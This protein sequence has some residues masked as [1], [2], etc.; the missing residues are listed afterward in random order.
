M[1]N[2][3]HEKLFTQNVTNVTFSF[4]TSPNTNPTR[5]S[6]GTGTWH[7]MPPPV[8]KSGGDTSPVS[9]TKLRPC[10]CTYSCITLVWLHHSPGPQPEGG[11]RAIA[12]PKFSQTYVFVRCSNKLHHFPPSK[13]SVGCGIATITKCP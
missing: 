8:W 5:K 1:C 9:P 3:S 2:I 7:I 11:N 6:G 4:E 12:P 13:I 10:L